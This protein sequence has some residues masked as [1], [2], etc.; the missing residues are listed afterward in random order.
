MKHR[1]R[2]AL[3]IAALLVSLLTVYFGG[4]RFAGK[5]AAQLQPIHTPE[6]AVAE[7]RG[8]DSRAFTDGV[9]GRLSD[10]F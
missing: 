5:T 3:L 9:D 10:L 4:Y 8:R 7:M 2:T 6:L 1:K